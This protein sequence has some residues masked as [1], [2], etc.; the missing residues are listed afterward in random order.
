M[1]KERFIYKGYTCDI[2]LIE[3]DDVCG[4]DGLYPTFKRSH[5]YCG[6]VVVTEDHSLYGVEYSEMPEDFEAN[7]NG[8]LTYSDK[9]ELGWAFG[10]DYAH[11]W[12]E[13]GGTID[14]VKRD[15]KA[16]ADALEAYRE[17]PY[18]ITLEDHYGKTPDAI[19]YR[20]TMY[21]PLPSQSLELLMIKPPRYKVIRKVDVFDD[22]DCIVTQTVAMFYNKKR[23]QDY[24]RFAMGTGDY[25]GSFYVEE[26]EQ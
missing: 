21:A 6:Y 5:W 4:M 22:E 18:L 15:C 16:L 1:L 12:N 2:K 25:R 20:G 9:H 23:A 10:F 11:C 19:E 7:V 17:K 13:S 14:E 8:G 24:C 26:D 3:H